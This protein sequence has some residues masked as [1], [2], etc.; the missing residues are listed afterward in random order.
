MTR[1]PAVVEQPPAE[2]PVELPPTATVGLVMATPTKPAPTAA[3]QAENNHLTTN[4]MDHTVLALNPGSLDAV[5][6]I[7]TS[8]QPG[9]IAEGNGSVWVV[10]EDNDSVVWIDAASRQ[11]MSSIPVQGFDLKTIAFGEG[12]VW[13]GVQEKEE[14]PNRKNPLMLGGVVTDDGESGEIQQY[15]STMRGGRYRLRRREGLGSLSQHEL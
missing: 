6:V 13:V 12:D 15:I 11:V 7:A 14:N 2:Q 4:R 8:G 3:P 1:P 9:D 10:D 5:A